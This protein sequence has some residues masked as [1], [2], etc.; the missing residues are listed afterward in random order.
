MNYREALKQAKA[1]RANGF[2]CHVGVIGLE[3][4]VILD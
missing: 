1:T 2:A 4:V 3:W